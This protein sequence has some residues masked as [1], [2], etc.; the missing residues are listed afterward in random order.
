MPSSGIDAVTAVT[1]PSAPWV[2]WA[3]VGRRMHRECGKECSRRRG[4]SSALVAVLKSQP[5]TVFV[6][7]FASSLGRL[8]ECTH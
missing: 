2:I 8:A 1:L 4:G 6:R 3:G 7:N 5:I